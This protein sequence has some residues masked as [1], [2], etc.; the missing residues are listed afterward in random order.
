MCTLIHFEMVPTKNE[1]KKVQNLV[2]ENR[3]KGRSEWY[4]NLSFSQ[5]KILYKHARGGYFTKSMVRFAY[6]DAQSNLFYMRV[7]LLIKYLT[8]LKDKEG[9]EE[10]RKEY[11]NLQSC[12]WLYFTKLNGEDVICRSE[13][14]SHIEKLEKGI[15]PENGKSLW[16]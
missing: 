16:E 13:S 15:Y 12:G 8:M 11:S 3:K 1:V 6:P 14:I 7:E 10:S 2:I 4:E 5:V 9:I